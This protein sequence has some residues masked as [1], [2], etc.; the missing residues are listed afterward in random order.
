M[1]KKPSREYYKIKTLHAHYYVEIWHQYPQMDKVFVGGRKKCVSFSVY[2]SENGKVDE[3]EPPQL[4]GFG[5]HP[6]CNSKGN[7]MKGIGS[8][9]LL[10]TSMAFLVDFYKMKKST[11]FQ[12]TDSS[13]I[14]C[15]KHHMP[16]CVYYI[17]FHGKTWYEYKFNAKPIY[18]DASLYDEQKRKLKAH[19]M[20]KPDISVYF[21][22]EQK[23][24]QEHVQ[25][26]YDTCQ[27]LKECLDILKDYD[28][29]IFRGW[30]VRLCTLFVPNII[31]SSWILTAEEYGTHKYVHLNKKP[32][33]L[34]EMQGGNIVFNRYEVK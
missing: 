12:Y 22:K 11:T 20:G 18:T 25:S 34:F 31:G 7:H 10:N 8:V 23:K 16:L 26:V 2:L 21:T 17:V 29:D 5:F 15:L 19:I 14:E 32:K 4:D 13:F 6:H 30:L 3:D 33:E 27:T 24:L 1:S 28:C 9:H